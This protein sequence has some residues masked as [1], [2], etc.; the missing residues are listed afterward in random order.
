VINNVNVSE[1]DGNS[2]TILVLTDGEIILFNF[3]FSRNLAPKIILSI[4]ASLFRVRGQRRVLAVVVRDGRLQR[5]DWTT[6]AAGATALRAAPRLRPAQTAWRLLAAPRSISGVETYSCPSHRSV[7][8]CKCQTSSSK[9][10][11]D[12]GQRDKR[13][14]AR[15]RIWCILAL[16]MWHL[17]VAIF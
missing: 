17:V 11:T 13:T 8:H 3:S 4:R 7:N 12:N 10:Q 14:G 1:F 2:L 5:V 16:N 15:N 9:T 6:L